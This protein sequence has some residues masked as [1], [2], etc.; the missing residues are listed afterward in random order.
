MLTLRKVISL[1]SS[2]SK[3]YI[4]NEFIF[5]ECAY[6]QNKSL[7]PIGSYERNK[8]YFKT[9]CQFISLNDKMICT[10]LVQCVRIWIKIDN[11]SNKNFFCISYNFDL[12]G[13]VTNNKNNSIGN[14]LKITSDMVARSEHSENSEYFIL[15]QNLQCKKP[16][17]YTYW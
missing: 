5:H 10:L 13:R 14:F 6:I 1:L 9:K 17:S 11:N 4:P 8:W 16:D 7:Y 15:T 2:I 3:F 12:F